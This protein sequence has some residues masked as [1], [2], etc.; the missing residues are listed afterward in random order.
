[1]ITWETVTQKNICMEDQIIKANDTQS[2]RIT[3]RHGSSHDWG[4]DTFK[5]RKPGNY[6][7][8]RKMIGIGDLYQLLY[9]IVTKYL[10]ETKGK[11]LIQLK[12]S[13]GW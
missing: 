8:S 12:V 7:M 13:D 2:A 6:H 3:E 4:P 5:L 11:L 10:A 1:M 9:S